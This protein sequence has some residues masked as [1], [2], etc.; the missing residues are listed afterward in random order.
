LASSILAN[1]LFTPLIVSEMMK[2]KKKTGK[3]AVEA[4]ERRRQA[5]MLLLSQGRIA[6]DYPVSVIIV[7]QDDAIN[8]SLI[9]NYHREAMH[10]SD[11]FQA[12]KALAEQGK[13]ELEIATEYG[14]SE[15]DVKRMLK[16][17]SA[18]PEIFKE[19]K[20]GNMGLDQIMVLCQVEDAEKQN[21]L[22]F[23][24]PEGWQ[25]N[26]SQLKQ[27]INEGEVEVSDKR[28]KFIGLGAY[29][30]AG[31]GIKADLFS[32]EGKEGV[33]LNTDLMDSLVHQKSLLI[34]DEIKAEGWGWVE[35]SV[36][37]SYDYRNSMNNIYKSSR[38]LTKAE[39]KKVASLAKQIEE[40]ETKMEAVPTEEDGSFTEDNEEIYDKLEAET[41][42]LEEQK[43]AVAENAMVWDEAQQ[44][45]A[46]VFFYLNNNGEYTRY[47]GLVKPDDAKQMKKDAKEKAGSTEVEEITEPTISNS[48]EETLTAHKN[49]AVQMRVARQPQLALVI[50]VHK[51]ALDALPVYQ[52]EYGDGTFNVSLKETGVGRYI[53]EYED[54]DLHAEREMLSDYWSNVV[55]SKADNL[56]QWLQEQD[57]E[58]LL[59]LL[60]YCTSLAVDVVPFGNDSFTDYA[61]MFG[62]NMNEFWKPTADN[63]FNR[64]SKKHMIVVSKEAEVDLS[65][66]DTDKL[67]KKDLAKLVGERVSK[68][69]WLPQQLRTV[70]L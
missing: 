62:V 13:T 9:E 25:R 8:A 30:K 21:T 51:M 2:A 35:F 56:M 18:T 60:A 34:A 20:D 70:K 37:D 39:E 61:T 31:G 44:P 6:D 50:L 66:L 10:P 26:A 7:E 63:Y 42:E 68:T 12:F 58:M 29:T 16:L 27:R 17:A 45:N 4:G 47:D 38:D 1:G 53:P 24:T 32:E 55:P 11:K 3:H 65:K 48:L 43:D 15:I 40:V 33:L 67:K 49:G 69:S 41:W 54:T 5:L 19:F 36:D 57:T 14:V 46:G 23:S 59:A 28:I 22:W 52:F 64:V